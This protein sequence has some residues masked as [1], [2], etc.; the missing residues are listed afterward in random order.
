[1]GRDSYFTS[2]MPHTRIDDD[3]A[4]LVWGYSLIAVGRMSQY[5]NHCLRW[6]RCL[7]SSLAGMRHFC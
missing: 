6:C 4:V 5:F 7:C 1:M 2:D 3:D